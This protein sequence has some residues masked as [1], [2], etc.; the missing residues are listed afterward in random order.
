[1]LTAPEPTLLP[2]EPTFAVARPATALPPELLRPARRLPAGQSL[3]EDGATGPLLVVVEAGA[4]VV[5]T[6]TRDGATAI[7][8]VLGPGE[9]TGAGLDPRLTLVPAETAAEGHW[10]L[11]RALVASRVTVLAAAEVWAA[12]E[13]HP[14]RAS[15]LA[16]LLAGA[17]RRS[18]DRLVDALVLPVRERVLA[19]LCD[20]VARFGG[21]RG[22]DG[23]VT[24]A[25]PVTQDLLAGLVGATRES[26]NRAVRSLTD[27]G[28]VEHEGRRYRVLAAS[29]TGPNRPSPSLSTTPLAS[30]SSRWARTDLAAAGYRSAG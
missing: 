9:A 26:V 12:A 3:V 29:C 21:N 7:E 8:D 24:I 23:M 16:R 20:L 30:S 10:H 25:L 17:L 18:Q 15:W 28:F 2:P 5:L 1:M 27:D 14:G 13:R 19:A 6:S 22:D 11:V 4:C